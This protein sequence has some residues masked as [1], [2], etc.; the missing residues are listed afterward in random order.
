MILCVGAMAGLGGCGINAWS[1]H[2]RIESVLKR[3][4]TV[5]MTP[6]AVAVEAEDIGLLVERPLE[7]QQRDEGEP[8]ILRTELQWMPSYIFFAPCQGYVF[9]YFDESRRLTGWNHRT[10]LGMGP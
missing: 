2:G 1:S 8:W 10:Y 4:F 7:A 3:H 6:A 5:G 9:F